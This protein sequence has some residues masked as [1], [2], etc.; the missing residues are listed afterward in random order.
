MQ[1]SELSTHQILT[2]LRTTNVAYLALAAEGQPYVIPMRYTLDAQGDTPVVCMSTSAYSLKSAI[3]HANP[4]VCIAFSLLG[5][6]WIDSVL[7]LGAA[8]LDEA[9]D[10]PQLSFTV[11]AEVLSGRRYYLT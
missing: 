7:L 8:Q 6:A 2:V 10:M 9:D 1:Y 5:C 3:L 11:P 4:Q